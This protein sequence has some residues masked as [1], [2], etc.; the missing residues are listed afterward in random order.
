VERFVTFPLELQ[1]TEVPALTELRWLTKVGLSRIT[2][3]FQDD[4][5]VNVAR[6]LVLERLIE[7][8]DSLPPGAD[9]TLVPNTTGSGEVWSRSIPSAVSSGRSRF[10][11]NRGSSG[12]II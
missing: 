10:S 11:S 9:P 7:A 1:L 8:R 5:K 4:M 3:V 2:V 6:Q 12:N